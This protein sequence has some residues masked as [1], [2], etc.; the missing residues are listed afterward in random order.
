[1]PW[2]LK[3]DFHTGGSPIFFF[4]RRPSRRL[5][6]IVV[7]I[8]HYYIV[9]RRVESCLLQRVTEFGGVVAVLD[10]RRV[11]DQ[12]RECSV[13]VRGDGRRPVR[14]FLPQDLRLNTVTKSTTNE[15][16]R[17]VE[18]GQ[19]DTKEGSISH[20]SFVVVAVRRP[21]PLFSII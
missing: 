18:L 17:V 8:V 12:P 9:V 11:G 16:Y 20:G 3:F 6:L 1:M 15:T 7:E 21:Q 5:R 10:S 4:C 19:F 14:S 13:H 2:R